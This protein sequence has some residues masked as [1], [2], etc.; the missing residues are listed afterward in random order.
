[1]SDIQSSSPPK[2]NP[3]LSPHLACRGQFRL[4]EGSEAIFQSDSGVL[5]A[6]AC[7]KA[8]WR[9]AA[10]LGAV[11]VEGERMADVATGEGGVVVVTTGMVMGCW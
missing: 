9:R 8:L 2:G 1:M 5:R 7:V 6:G 10:S 11:T 4:E 3:F